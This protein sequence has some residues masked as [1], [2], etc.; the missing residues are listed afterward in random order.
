MFGRGDGKNMEKVMERTAYSWI[1]YGNVK[2]NESKNF[3]YCLESYMRTFSFR[4]WKIN[5]KL[6]I[7]PPQFDFHTDTEKITAVLSCKH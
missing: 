7:I 4:A 1:E 2:M 3:N 5:F 6:L